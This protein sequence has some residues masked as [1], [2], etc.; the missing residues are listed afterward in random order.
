MKT[1]VSILAFCWL[2]AGSR[3]FA[4]GIDQ[5]TA[6][7]LHNDGPDGSTTFID[8]AGNHIGANAPV[9]HGN[10]QIDALQNKFG[11]AS[12]L[13]NAN[14]LNNYLTLTDHADWNFGN[15]NFTIDLWAKFTTVPTRNYNHLVE[16][17]VSNAERWFFAY[18]GDGHLYFETVSTFNNMQVELNKVIATAWQDD[19]W[20]HI[21]IVRN[22]NT[23]RLYQNGVQVGSEVTDTDTM[24]DFSSPLYIGPF[25]EG[26]FNTDMW[27]DEV[28][29]SKGIARWTSNFTPPSAPYDSTVIPEP[30]TLLTLGLSIFG[31]SLIKRKRKL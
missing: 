21:A 25:K 23:W 9:A 28:R 30:A 7:M 18:V 15:G 1:I 4:E 31:I 26:V 13:F 19:T 14:S 12:G 8:S 24:P 10:A 20:Y 16:Q 3:A 6:L 11:T 22:V 5:Y 2:M 27:L 17:W 29:I